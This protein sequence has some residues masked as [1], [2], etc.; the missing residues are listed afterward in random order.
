MSGIYIPNVEI[1]SSCG[2]CKLSGTGICK[3]WLTM[4]KSDVGSKRS[5]NCP[6]IP[7]PD[8]GDLTDRDAYRGNFVSQI[9]DICADDNDNWR[10]NAIIDLYDNAPAIIPASRET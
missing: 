2:E 10:A 5:E 3:H 6:A 9:Y 7:V 1:P 4:K 8:H